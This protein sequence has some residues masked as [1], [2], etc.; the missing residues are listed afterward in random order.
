MV[1]LQAVSKAGV[2]GDVGGAPVRVVPYTIDYLLQR[3]G[4][5]G[6]AECF[7]KG[8]EL[9]GVLRKPVSSVFLQSHLEQPEIREKPLVNLKG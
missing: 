7:I 8:A 5:E 4:F 1:V 6:W 2:Y 9:E 3:L